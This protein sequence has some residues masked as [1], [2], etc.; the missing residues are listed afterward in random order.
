M[1]RTRVGGKHGEIGTYAS[2]GFQFRRLP[3]RSSVRSGFTNS[4]QMDLPAAETTVHQKP[5]KLLSQ[6]V[7]VPSWTP[8]CNREAG[9]GRSPPHETNSVAPEVTLACARE[10]GKDYSN[11][12]L[13]PSTPRL[14]VR[15][16]QC[17]QGL[18]LTPPSTRSTDI[19]RRLKRR[20][21]RT[22]RGIHSKR[23]LVRARKS[24]PLQLLGAQGSSSGPQEF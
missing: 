11:S 4:G 19:Y 23:R 5:E 24:S 18:A 20:V 22:L 2:T 6:T 21:G 9:M 10:S 15:R 16:A 1:L 3:V 7:H 13:V 17:T 12:S 8:Y 14:V